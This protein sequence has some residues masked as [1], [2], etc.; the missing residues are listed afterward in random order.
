MGYRTRLEL[1][2]SSVHSI[3][4]RSFR[5]VVDCYGFPAAK[6]L[7]S[8]NSSNCQND[9]AFFVDGCHCWLWKKVVWKIGRCVAWKSAPLG[10][11]RRLGVD[12]VNC[13]EISYSSITILTSF[14]RYRKL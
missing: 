2:R 14:L 9:L 8:L 12:H 13:R 6:F 4:E 10:G 7:I 5:Y 11:V 3:A 1:W